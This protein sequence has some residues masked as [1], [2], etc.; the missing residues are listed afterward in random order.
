MHYHSLGIRVG[1]AVRL[2]EVIQVAVKHGFADLVRRIGLHEGLPAKLLRG[3]HLIEAPS[4]EPQTFG[5]RLRAALIEL[6]PTFI[7]AGQILSTRPDLVSKEVC[8]A[9]SLLQDQ[10]DPLPFEEMEPVL[11]AN[12]GGDVDTLFR[13][14]DRE[15]MAAASL[16]QVYRAELKTGEPVVVKAQRPGIREVIE[17][18]LQLLTRIAEWAED[19]MHDVQWLDPVGTVEEFG[20]SIFRELDFTIEARII[21]RFRENYK[22]ESQIFVPKTYDGFCGPQVLTMDWVDGVRVD[23]Y[24]EYPSRGCDPKEVARIGCD[25]IS[26]QIFKFHLFHADP[27][28]GNVFVIRDNQIAFLDYGMVGH[29]ER[30]DVAAIADLFR[31]I[32]NDDP[33]ACVQALLS[34]TTT[35]DVVERNLLMH[36]VS[37][38]I[39][40]EAQT[41]LGRANVGRVIEKL[42][43]ILRRHK[44]QL[45]PR[46][47]LLLKALATVESTAHE[48]DPNLNMVPL[49]QPYVEDVIRKRF[50]PAQIAADL[51]QNALAFLRLGKELP[52]DAQQL[53]VMLRRGRLKIQLNHEGLA[54]LANVAD[55]ASNRLTFGVITGSIIVGSSML[56]AADIGLRPIGLAG[57]SVAGLLGLALVISIIRSR[58]L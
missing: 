33:E 18:D 35:P 21:E 51:Q 28:P 7:K 34:F 31:G 43:N 12:L 47:S 38:F 22:G 50:A 5:K 4:G 40:F 11:R 1:N 10:V 14:F 39:A 54:H 49:I 45:A 27:H 2:A 20:R 24:E 46:F 44:L 30:P 57:Y 55:R 3:L 25:T 15:P 29:L 41:V 9:L 8:D 13:R 37:D 26:K 19:H 32:F 58:N 56:L 52:R 23:A 6:G 17:S 16:S 53:M 48:L 36:E 42:T